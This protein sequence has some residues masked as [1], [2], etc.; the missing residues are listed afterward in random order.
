MF[1]DEKV[2]SNRAAVCLKL[3][4]YRECI[5]DSTT[6]ISMDNNFLKPYFRRGQAY[7]ALTKYKEA[8]DDYQFILSKD[9]KNKKVTQKLKKCRT[10]W[11]KKKVQAKHLPK[12]MDKIEEKEEEV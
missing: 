9:P 4:H 6:A 10:K 12:K 11:Q 3:K 7:Q 1:K 5:D 8:I 2:Y